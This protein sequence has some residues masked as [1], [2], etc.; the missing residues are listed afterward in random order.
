MNTKST[1]NNIETGGITYGNVGINETTYEMTKFHGSQGHGFAA[2]RAEHI[3]DIYQGND[4]Q[5]L[6][7]DNAKNGADRLVNGVEIQSKYCETGARCIQECFKDGKYRYYSKSG[8]PMQV[9]VPRDKYNDALKA[10][11]RRIERGEVP[12]ISDPKD[13]EKLV[14]KGHYTYDQARRIAQSGTVESLLFDAANGMVI[15]RNAMGVTAVISFATSIWDGEDF[16]T[17]LQNAALSGI[18]V[19]GVSFFTTVISSQIARTSINASVRT[20]T[21]HVVKLLGPK[22]T[23]YIANALRNGTNIYGAAA[24]NNVSK[25][26]S[27]NIIAST[28]SLVVLSSKDISDIFRGRISGEQFFKDV[29]TTGASIAG[30]GAGWVAGTAAGGTVGGVIGA[31]ISGP[32]GAAVGAKVGSKIGAFVGSITGGTVAGHTTHTVLDSVIEDDS[33]KMLSI[34]E[35]C[36]I[37]ISEEYLLT[38]NEVEQCVDKLKTSITIEKLKDM[39]AIRNK[40]SYAHSMVMGIVN[41]IIMN[42]AYVENISEDDILYGIRS[43]VEDAIDGTG[44]FDSSM[45][46]SNYSDFEKAVVQNSNIKEE[47]VTQIM[48][49]VMKINNTQVRTEKALYNIKRSNEAFNQ[50]MDEIHN[51]R[52]NLK[53]ELNELFYKK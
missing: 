25:L 46:I 33:K 11:Q 38:Q 50:K 27:G 10:M 37:S 35:K 9:E 36:F 47:Q 18:K 5:I 12:G 48:A 21:D 15:A 39:Y 40:E 44:L 2:E 3:V 41:P 20:G 6:G 17:A 45:A 30:G 4:A 26:L 14:K 53:A 16:D 42:R 7:D 34:I 51:E 43:L 23:S 52:D 13:A 1:N 31:A 22:A 24:M 28:V 8:E 29:S 49:P 19:G 32:A